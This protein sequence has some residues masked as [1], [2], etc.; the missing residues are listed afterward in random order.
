MDEVVPVRAAVA[1]LTTLPTPTFFE[2]YVAASDVRATFVGLLSS[3][4]GTLTR[5][6]SDV[7]VI[8]AAFDRLYT[9]V[10]ATLNVPPI[11]KGR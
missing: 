11:V 1:T 8:A 4:V 2:S 5:V 3:P 7:S 9:L 10:L 6:R